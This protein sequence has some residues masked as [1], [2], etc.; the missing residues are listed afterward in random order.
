MSALDIMNQPTNVDI[1]NTVYQEKMQLAREGKLVEEPVTTLADIKNMGSNKSKANPRKHGLNSDE[2]G[3]RGGGGGSINEPNKRVK[4]DEEQSSQPYGNPSSSGLTSEKRENNTSFPNSLERISTAS[5]KPSNSDL[6]S[7]AS[8]G[9]VNDTPQQQNQLLPKILT[10]PTPLNNTF[11]RPFSFKAIR[12]ERIGINE[13][14]M[15]ETIIFDIQ[16]FIESLINMQLSSSTSSSSINSTGSATGTDFNIYLLNEKPLSPSLQDGYLRINHA[17]STPRILHPNASSGTMNSIISGIVSLEQELKK[18]S[19]ITTSWHVH[20]LPQFQQFLLA[21][22]QQYILT[23]AAN[24]SST[25]ANTT[26]SNATSPSAASI[27]RG[28]SASGISLHQFWNQFDHHSPSNHGFSSQAPTPLSINTSSNPLMSG[29]VLGC[30]GYEV[31]SSMMLIIREN[32]FLGIHSDIWCKL[33]PNDFTHAMEELLY[34][35]Q[36]QQMKEQQKEGNNHDY[37]NTPSIDSNTAKITFG[38]IL[39]YFFPQLSILE[40]KLTISS[41]QLSQKKGITVQF[42]LDDIFVK[43][44]PITPSPQQ[45]SSNIA[46]DCSIRSETDPSRSAMSIL[47]PQGN[48]SA[49]Q[50]IGVFTTPAKKILARYFTPLVFSFFPFNRCL[51]RLQS[52]AKIHDFILEIDTEF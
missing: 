21:Y 12:F 30:I 26:M 31:S 45:P 36:Q 5:E 3:S 48:T 41:Q 7:S 23:A 28:K 43:Y 6:Y 18:L 50:T 38:D 1:A 46:D 33:Y 51:S 52:Q 24:A 27:T 22:Y 14:K 29:L 19:S 39:M 15:K 10:N 11:I 2:G 4:Y 17:I 35:L 8:E 16:Q 25:P 49:Y 44:A 32:K 37:H 20:E 40:R 42:T 34:P 47:P 13:W 9:S